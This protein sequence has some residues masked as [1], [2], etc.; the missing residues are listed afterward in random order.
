MM[1]EQI[2]V[3]IVRPVN[4]A[5]VSFVK[6]L[7]G[8]VGA[9]NRAVLQNYRREFS[10]L[11]QKLGFMIDEKIGAGKMITGKIIVELDGDRPVRARAVDLKIWDVVGES[12]EE[13]VVEAE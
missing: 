2:E 7:W 5:G 13:I 10:R 12:K 6:Y 8:A 9:R 1:T 4:P 3:E 11:I